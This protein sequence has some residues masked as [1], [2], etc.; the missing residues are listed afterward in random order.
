[1]TGDYE[2]FYKTNEGNF[3]DINDIQNGITYDYTTITSSDDDPAEMYIQRYGEYMTDDSDCKSGSDIGSDSEVDI[4]SDNEIDSELYYVNCADD[5]SDEFYGNENSQNISYNHN[6]FDDIWANIDNKRNIIN[7]NKPNYKR[8][9]NE[10][11]DQLMVTLTN[12][13]SSKYACSSKD[14]ETTAGRFLYSILANKFNYNSA[15]GRFI[16][17]KFGLLSQHFSDNET[18]DE[19]IDKIINRYKLGLI[20]R[21]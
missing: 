12:F 11:M 16:Y 10:D 13:I 2:R 18:F 17:G 4:G 9:S 1:M 19:I 5:S 6:T 7:T 15:E 21:N 14:D 8:H 20:Y 3:T